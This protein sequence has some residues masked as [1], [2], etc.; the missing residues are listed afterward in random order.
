M[1]RAGKNR[2]QGR[3]EI[4]KE[5]AQAWEKQRSGKSRGQGSTENTEKYI[6]GKSKEDK[7]V[8]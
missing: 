6:S 1:Q 7:R 2:Q 3:A 5:K 4:W 8:V